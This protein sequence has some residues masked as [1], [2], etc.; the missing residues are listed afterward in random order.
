MSPHTYYHLLMPISDR[1]PLATSKQLSSLW[2]RKYI[3][4]QFKLCNKDV[5]K[6]VTHLC[7][8]FLIWLLPEFY[9]TSKHTQTTFPLVSSSSEL[10][11]CSEW[12]TYLNHNYRLYNTCN[13]AFTRELYCL[14]VSSCNKQTVEWQYRICLLSSLVFC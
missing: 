8:L 14:T 5:W 12:K 3:Q 4:Y 2:M 11:Y 10:P 6:N 9:L 1:L 13:L 7:F